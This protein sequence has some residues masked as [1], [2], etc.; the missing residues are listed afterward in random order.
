MV[1]GMN[2]GISL[3]L[4]MAIFVILG[5]IAITF[6]MMSTNEFK[7]SKFIGDS[8]IA[9]HSAEAGLDF[10]IASVPGNL[11]AFPALPDTWITLANNAQYKSGASDSPPTPIT[12]AGTQYMVGYSIEQG[13]DFYSL[14]YDMVTSGK[15][16]R[17]TR[18]IK[19]RV[20][21][22]PLPGGTQY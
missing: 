21:C 10:G 12:L 19:A 3:V 17:S 7:M 4:V 9:F 22:G 5:M 15:M 18:E 8:K 1:S 20:K 6:I 2:K 13:A 16:N 11:S 14:L